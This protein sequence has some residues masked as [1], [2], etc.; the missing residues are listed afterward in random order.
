MKRKLPI[1][2]VASSAIM[3]AASTIGS[4]KATLT[5]MSDNYLFEHIL[6]RVKL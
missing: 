2:L 3:L 5:Y 4:T 6:F 1:I